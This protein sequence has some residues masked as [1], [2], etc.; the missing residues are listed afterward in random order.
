V[1]G[2]WQVTESVSTPCA[3]PCLQTFDATHW[4]AIRTRSRHEKVAAHQLESQGIDV[5]LPLVSEVRKW[6]DRRKQI[7]AALFPG[8]AFVQIAYS[9][10]DRLRV[11]Q[12]HGV[13]NF[14]GASGAVGTP[15]PD[16]Q[17]ESIR[18]LISRNVPFKEY[19]FLRVGQRIR[20]RGGSLDGLEGLLVAL[21]GTRTLVIS[22]EPIQRS[23]CIKVDGYNIEV[24]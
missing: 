20:I 13:A 14:V 5:F 19:P 10:G 15:I 18:T 6:S 12:T 7:E 16:N 2:T 11:L 24:I 17:I 1:S 21:N 4:Y 23:L 3:P 8:Y 22:V 9:S